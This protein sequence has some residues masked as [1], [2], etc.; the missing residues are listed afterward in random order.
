MQMIMVICK[1]YIFLLHLIH[2][3]NQWIF[4]NRVNMFRF[5]INKK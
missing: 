3:G 5:K 4:L 2:F 1:F